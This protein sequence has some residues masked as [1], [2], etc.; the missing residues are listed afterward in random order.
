MDE[1]IKKKLQEQDEKLDRIYVSVEKTRKYFLWTMISTGVMFIVP[2]VGL[3]IVIPPL[4]Q[5]L[6]SIYGL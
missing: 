3:A 2:L 1:E 6:S 4:L 5:S